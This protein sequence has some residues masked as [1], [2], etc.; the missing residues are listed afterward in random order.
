MQYSSMAQRSMDG[1]QGSDEDG[2]EGEVE[3]LVRLAR[4]HLPQLRTIDR[5]LVTDQSGDRYRRQRFRRV[6]NSE[7]MGLQLKADHQ[8]SDPGDAEI[9]FLVSEEVEVPGAL[10]R[11]L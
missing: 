9:E 11:V 10:N 7:Q 3:R 2:E 1:G 6:L 8:G 5:Q 4:E